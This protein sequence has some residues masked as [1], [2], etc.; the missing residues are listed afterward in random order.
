LFLIVPDGFLFLVILV[1]EQ[2]MF[3][4][5]YSMDKIEF[6]DDS[7]EAPAISSQAS[8]STWTFRGNF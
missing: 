5:S 3:E 1:N 2:L 7:I 8:E 4:E 6:I